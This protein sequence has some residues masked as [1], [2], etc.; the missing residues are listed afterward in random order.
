MTARP[1]GPE[2][3]PQSLCEPGL[4]PLWASVR[5]RLDSRGPDHR[6]SM[7][8]PDLDPVSELTLRSL[9]GHAY[10]RLD[11]GRLEE[12]LVERLIG[13]DL[14]DALSR[15]GYPPSKEAAQRRMARTRLADA[16]SALRDAVEPWPEPWAQEWAEAVIRAGL[17]G[18]LDTDDVT[19][20]A[21]DVRQLLDYL[22]STASRPPPAPHAVISPDLEG[23]PGPP[24]DDRPDGVDATGEVA[25]P[26]VSRTDLAAV[27]FG[28]AHALDPG[29]RL[30]AFVTRALRLHVGEDLDGRELWEAAGVQADRV[31][32]PALVW[33]VPATGRSALAELLRGS[34]DGGLPLHTSLLALHRHPVSVPAGTQ[35]LAV[36]NPRLVEAAAERDLACCVVATNGNPA[37]AVTTLLDQMR[38]SGAT[39][40]YHGD[41]DAAGIAI[42]RRM[43]DSGSTP[44][45]MA[46]GDYL[47]A[48][49]KA[50]EGGVR[51]EKDPKACGPT[52]WDPSLEQAFDTRR[53]MV[54]Q[55][56]VLDE[57]LTTFAHMAGGASF[58]RR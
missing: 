14:D 21:H 49:Q 54:H 34:A 45:M 43:H 41:F 26:F 37:T 50:T 12:V 11:L 1:A 8:R 15:L 38:A 55:E 51:L 5:A 9:L 10:K 29:L 35:V 27:L 23:F 47:N 24:T 25:S 36:E 22:G 44:W 57:V 7:R 40:W 3:V 16:R 39:V 6:G 20:V 58:R 4:R 28:S 53:L 32:A 42:C 33:A 31:S 17:H 30:T 19:T 48:I 13:R 46:A 52:P 18:G 56:F 2:P